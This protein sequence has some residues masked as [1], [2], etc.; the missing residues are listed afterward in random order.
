M[1]I[2]EG[3]I[4]HP[5]TFNAPAHGVPLEFC[6]GGRTRCSIRWWDLIMNT[7]TVESVD[8]VCFRAVSSVI[9]KKRDEGR[10]CRASTNLPHQNATVSQVSWDACRTPVRHRN[11]VPLTSPRSALPRRG[12]ANR[13]RQ[14]A[15]GS[16][17]WNAR[18]GPL[19]PDRPS[20]VHLSDRPLSPPPS[21]CCC[22]SGGGLGPWKSH[23]ASGDRIKNK[24]TPP[25]PPWCGAHSAAAACA[26]NWIRSIWSP[27]LTWHEE[28][29][30]RERER[31][32]EREN[33][34]TSLNVGGLMA[35][36][37]NTGRS[38]ASHE[39]R[40]TSLSLSSHRWDE[41]KTLIWQNANIHV[42]QYTYIHLIWC[43]QLGLLIIWFNAKLPEGQSPS[44]LAT[45]CSM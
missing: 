41:K 37:M 3:K 30:Q 2:F 10:G 16:A 42:R 5:R 12:S 40:V 1:E 25:P 24:M 35:S 39:I 32:R 15:A 11:E 43:Y 22:C 14:I 9:R 4:S 38:K 29:L 17:L 31:E 28:M 34:V 36:A 6:D 18:R 44:K 7:H 19:G 21:C 13:W 45:H 23:L 8:Y 26:E 27:T 33:V 20:V